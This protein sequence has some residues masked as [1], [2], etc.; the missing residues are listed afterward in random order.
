MSRR[1][2]KSASQRASPDSEDEFVMVTPRAAAAAAAA[3]AAE[4]GDAAP[5]RIKGTPEEEE[6]YEEALEKAYRADLLGIEL[7]PVA[8]P[9]HI[10]VPVVEPTKVTFWTLLFRCDTDTET[11]GQ[12]DAKWASGSGWLVVANAS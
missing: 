6:A 8:P 4:S 10:L 7:P 2:A 3:K 9:G 11:C 1:S 5:D 12:F